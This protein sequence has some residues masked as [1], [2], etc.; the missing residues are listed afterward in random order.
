MECFHH[1]LI[2]ARIRLSQADFC[3]LDDMIEQAITSAI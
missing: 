2:D 3:R 1:H